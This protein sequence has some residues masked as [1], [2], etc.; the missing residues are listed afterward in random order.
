M[1]GTYLLLS[2]VSLDVQER[3]YQEAMKF[4]G[5]SDKNPEERIRFLLEAPADM[6]LKLPP[7]SLVATTL[8]NDLIPSRGSFNEVKCSQSIDP[9]GK[10]WC[11]DILI[12][13]ASADVS[14]HRYQD[15]WLLIY[16]RLASLHFFSRSSLKTV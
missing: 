11:Q 4:W 8:D 16:P 9:L 6:L 14:T 12:G 5:L 13:D 2:P 1:S 15:L 7:S 10:S 3:S